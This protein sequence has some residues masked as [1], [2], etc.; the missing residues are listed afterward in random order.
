MYIFLRKNARALAYIKYLLYLCRLFVRYDRIHQRNINGIE[1]D[2][3][4][5]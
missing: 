3:G 2:G 4:R 1:P 5:D